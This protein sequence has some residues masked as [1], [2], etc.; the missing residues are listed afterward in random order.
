MHAS[1]G[2]DDGTALTALHHAD[3]HVVRWTV[4]LLGNV[5]TVS[6]LS[7][8]RFSKSQPGS[9]RRLFRRNW[10]VPRSACPA[11]QSLPL[12]EVLLAHR[13]ATD[14]QIPLLCWWALESKCESDRDAVLKV[15]ANSALW[16]RPMVEQH[17]LSR[18]MRRYAAAGTRKDLLTCA[19]LLELSPSTRHTKLL[20]AGFEEA[21]AGRSLTGLP[22][23]LIKALARHDV[24]SDALKLRTGDSAVLTR[25][26]RTIADPKAETKRRQQLISVIGEV[27]PASALE[28]SCDSPTATLTGRF[29]SPRSPP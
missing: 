8:V 22:D 23:E 14:G 16:F 10:P 11:A 3:S 12:L 25:A 26:L 9:E 18:L 13:F 15:F 4:E 28:T 21:F 27:R 5:G 29:A 17:I 6:P 20:M 7:F 1:G 24:G 19:R 2:F